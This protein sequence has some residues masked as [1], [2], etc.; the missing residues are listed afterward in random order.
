MDSENAWVLERVKLYELMKQQPDWSLRRY[1]RELKHDLQWVRRWAA[2]I[3][4][5]PVLT[6]ETFRSRSR[7]PYHPPPR[8]AEE[9]KKM[10]GELRR[11][12]TEQFHRKAGAKTILY[13]LQKYGQT[14]RLTFALPKSVQHHHPHSARLGLDY[15]A[16]LRVAR[17]ARPPPTNGRMGD[18]F[19]GNLLRRRRWRL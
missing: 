10:V 18:G 17:A 9:V 3:R 19:R 1:A 14:Q 2:R 6:L 7:A 11:E 8:I 4:S 15:A 13:G 16:P 12:L 5:A